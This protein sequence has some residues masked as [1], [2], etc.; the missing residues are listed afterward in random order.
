MTRL[1]H[2]PI[3]A[4]VL[5]LKNVWFNFLFN[6]VIFCFFVIHQV[7]Y[8]HHL[9]FLLQDSV[10]FFFN[11]SIYVTQEPGIEELIPITLS[12]I[13]PSIIQCNSKLGTQGAL[14]NV[15]LVPSGVQKR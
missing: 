1:S 15:S 6:M 9:F 13:H 10:Y 11:S 14:V 2:S 12:S 7:S 8:Y 3:Q 4:A 5:H